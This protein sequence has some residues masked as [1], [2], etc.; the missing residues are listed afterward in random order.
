MFRAMTW[1]MLREGVDVQDAAAVAAR[2]G[3]PAIISG[4]DPLAPD[5]HGRRHRRGG[6][7]PRPRRSPA[8][9][10]PGQRGDRRSARGCWS[11]SAEIIGRRDGGIV[12]EGRDIGSV[13]APRR[14]QGLPDRRP[15]GPGRPPGRGGGRRR[16]VADPRRRCWPATRSTPGAPP[17]RWRRPTVPSTST[18]RRTPWTR[19]SGRSSRS[20]RRCEEPA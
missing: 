20:C 16:R 9:V 4:T 17:R 6:R 5:D 14:G 2:V 11:C 3:E 12:V 1:W 18:P 10:S 15:G 7:D 8:A 13:V 19:S